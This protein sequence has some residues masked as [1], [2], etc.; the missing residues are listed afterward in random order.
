M[1]EAMIPGGG[2]VGAG[3]ERGAGERADAGFRDFA[4]QFFSFH[5]SFT[6]GRA[7]SA[8][9]PMI[10][11][12]SGPL[13]YLAGVVLAVGVLFLVWFLWPVLTAFQTRR[14]PDHES[15]RTFVGPDGHA[16]GAFPSIYDEG[17]SRSYVFL[18]VVVP[19]Y[20]EEERI[21]AMLDETLA[22]L[23]ARRDNDR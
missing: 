20:N 23:V 21:S 10:A 12:L 2:G 5:L 11:L 14:T 19:A 22:H 16:D 3:K 1:C 17:P 9:H 7:F 4:F 6:V 15:E 18:S 8:S 13:A